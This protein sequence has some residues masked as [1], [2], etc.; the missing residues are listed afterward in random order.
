MMRFVTASFAVILAAA[1]ALPAAAAHKGSHD[2]QGNAFGQANDNNAGGNGGG[3][4]NGA[5]KGKG[6]GP[7]DEN[8]GGKHEK[9]GGAPAQG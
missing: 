6:H 3:Q 9:W 5:D 7:A 8:H 2:P 4:A 1:F